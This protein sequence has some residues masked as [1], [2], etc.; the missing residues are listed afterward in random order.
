M[1]DDFIAKYAIKGTVHD[2]NAF[3]PTKFFP[4]ELTT[5]RNRAFR[6]AP[7]C[8][9]ALQW[10]SMAN[11]KERGK[12]ITLLSEI[13]RNDGDIHYWFTPVLTEIFMLT[14]LEEFMK[15]V[16]L[17][18]SDYT[19]RVIRKAVDANRVK[20]YTA[21]CMESDLN[22]EGYEGTKNF[23]QLII[24]PLFFVPSIRTAGIRR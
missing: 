2:F 24:N 12:Y 13:E 3:G 1:K 21:Y 18:I 4:S 8:A 7:M 5:K 20:R 15:Y 19:C 17:P 6:D 16:A 14:E 11:K 10:K 22:P 9:M 23:T